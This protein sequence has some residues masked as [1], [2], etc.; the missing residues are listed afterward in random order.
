MA[1]NKIKKCRFGTMVYNPKDLFIG[2]SLDRYGEFSHGE[3]ELFRQIVRPGDVVVEV[4]A[5]IGAHTVHLARLVG[6]GGAIHAFEPQRLVFQALCA[7]MALNGV[8]RGPGTVLVPQ[9]DPDVAQNFGGLALG[10]GLEGERVPM[11]TID[12]RPLGRCRLIK[13]DVEGMERDVLLGAAGTIRRHRPFL[14]VEN[15]RRDRSDDLIR[16]LDGLGYDL[17]WHR[18]PLYNPDNYLGAPE[19]VFGSLVSANMLGIPPD[20]PVVVRGFDRVEVPGP[21]ASHPAAVRAREE[22][23]ASAPPAPAGTPTR[24]FPSG[25]LRPRPSRRVEA[26]RCGS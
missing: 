13:I 17:Y 24:A 18:P 9:L 26:G 1:F 12:A 7:N 11:T 4:G 25:P 16:H 19:N 5:N 6:S 2:R 21:G 8:G 20:E 10:G 14:Y 23:V 15:D 22:S 3:S